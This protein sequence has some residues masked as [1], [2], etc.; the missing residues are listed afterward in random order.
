MIEL[1]TALALL[2]IYLSSFA[3]WLKARTDGPA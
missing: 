1:F 3:D 2:G